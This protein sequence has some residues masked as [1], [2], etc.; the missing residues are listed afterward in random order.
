M[1]HGQTVQ[2][3]ER[4]QKDGW[5]LPSLYCMYP[6][7]VGPIIIHTNMQNNT[8]TLNSALVTKCSLLIILH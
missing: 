3:A 8:S 6:P 4:T 7:A 2:T 5:M 1:V